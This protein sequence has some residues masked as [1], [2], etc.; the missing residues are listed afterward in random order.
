MIDDDVAIALIIVAVIAARCRNE[1][2][3]TAASSGTST[4]WKC[5]RSS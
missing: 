2:G 1:D 4:I 3:A 5:S